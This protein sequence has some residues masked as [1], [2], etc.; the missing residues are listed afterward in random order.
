MTSGPTELADVDPFD[1]PDWLGQAEVTWTATSG[2]RSGHLVTGELSADGQDP[3]DCDL[4]AVD[5]A[6][7]EPVAG[8]GCRSRAHQLWQH[9]EVLVAGRGGRLTLAVP[10]TSFNADLV[11]ETLGRLSRAVGGSPEHYV[12]R[13]RI[14]AHR[15]R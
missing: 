13:L 9:G 6:F 14:G 5:Q 2:V 10:G 11:L 3:L 7:P 1:L 4:L 12:A 8:E 15:S